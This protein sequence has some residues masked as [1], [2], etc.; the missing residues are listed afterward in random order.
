MRENIELYFKHIPD[1]ALNVN[2]LEYSV[3]RIK[4]MDQQKYNT[5]GM[6]RKSDLGNV[7]R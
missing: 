7:L 5:L 4:H 3:T 2:C 6:K 1:L